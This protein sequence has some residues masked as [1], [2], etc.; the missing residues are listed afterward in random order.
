MCFLR[1]RFRSSV[2][3]L[4]PR[5]TR[6]RA[7]AFAVLAFAL[8][9]PRA[10]AQSAPAPRPSATIKPP[11]VPLHAEV[12][13]DTNKLGQVSHVVSMKPSSDKGFNTQVWGNA[14]QAYIR[15]PEGSAVAGLYR[16]SYDYSPA[17]QKVRRS[18]SLLKTGGV[19]PNAPGIVT[20]LQK[21]LDEAQ[22]RQSQPQ[23]PA[24]LPDFDK[25]TQPTPSH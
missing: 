20:V 16:L 3:K 24:K 12:F 23:A 4:T 25:I 22:K 21:S 8:V 17:T 5:A 11:K 15:T 1:R 7:A 14:T 6:L 19:N 18:V 9:C 2:A 13:V 10:Q